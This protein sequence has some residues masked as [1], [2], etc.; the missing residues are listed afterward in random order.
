DVSLEDRE[1][2]M[3]FLADTDQFFLNIAMATGKAMADAARTIEHGTI[4]TAM[5]RNGENFGILIAGMGDEWFTAPVNTPQDLY[6]NGYSTVDSNTDI[7][8]SVITEINGV[9]C[10]TMIAA[11]AVTR[12]VGSGG[13]N[14]ALE[15][16]NNIAEITQQ[17]NPYF[18]NPSWD[19]RGAPTGID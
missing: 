9:G 16:S 8:D 6:F 4:V 7:C 17:E 1:A 2:V 14:D 3:Q 19:F 12:F 18:I 15:T 10:M 5:C 13:F 11:T